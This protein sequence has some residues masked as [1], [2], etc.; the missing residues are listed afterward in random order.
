MDKQFSRPISALLTKQWNST[1]IWLDYKI[2]IVDI[3]LEYFRMDI[4]SL[5]TKMSTNIR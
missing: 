3:L 5:I 1:A 4:G 2:Y